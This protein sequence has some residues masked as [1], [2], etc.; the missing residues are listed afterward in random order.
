[1][2]TYHYSEPSPFP[3]S[4][5]GNPFSYAFGLFGDVVIA[6][7]ST[8]IFLALVLEKRRLNYTL[9]N[10]GVLPF[11]YR[12]SEGFPLVEAHRL[13]IMSFWLF[14]ALRSVPDALW[15]LAWGEVPENVIRILL[16]TDLVFDG[17]AVFPCLVAL[18]CWA[19]S[20]SVIE[21]QLS[22]APTGIQGV[23]PW[24]TVKQN[25]RIILLVFIVAIGVTI[26]KAAG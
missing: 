21:Q 19:W 22:K 9:E 15:M 25:G 26:G 7:L 11:F 3:P 20:R 5:D 6:A 24:D 8:A 13:K 23:V 16:A 18:L 1:M 2:V 12:R 10:I 4:F 17:L 14:V